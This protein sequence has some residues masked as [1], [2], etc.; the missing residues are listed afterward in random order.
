MAVMKKIT[1]AEQL[2][3]IKRNTVEIIPEGDLYRKLKD[4]YETGIPLKC[5]LGFDP[6]AP[7]LHLGHAVVLHKIREFQDLGHEAVIILGD[8]TGRIGDPTG[9]AEARKQMSEEEVLANARTYREQVYKILDP[10]KTEL[11]FNS[12]W[13]AELKFARIIELSS[14]ITVARMLEREDFSRRYREGVPISLHEFFYPLMQG[15]DSVAIRA[16]VELGATE[17]KFNLLMGRFL[18]K[19][20]GQEPQITLT[21]PILIGTDGLQK[22]SKSLGNYIGITDPPGEMYGKIMSIND[23]SMLEYFSLATRLSPGEIEGIRRD[24]DRGRLHPRDAKMRLGH[25]IVALYHGKEEASRAEEEF[26]RVFQ[27]Q[28]LPDEIPLIHLDSSNW[29]TPADLIRLL[30]HTGMVSSN[31]EARRLIQQGGVRVNGKKIKEMKTNIDISEE[32]L[33]QIG[34]R[35]FIKV[36]IK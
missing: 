34:K 20:Y 12:S 7:D 23:E 36:L 1:P 22:M 25:E 6:S 14:K 17:Q 15:Y 13:L 28:G 9:R 16:D 31:S 2:E 10:A 29:E 8:F 4:S 11:I 33:L 26:R 5:K 24:L 18:Q 30:A 19:E 27:R 3:I 35:K 32:T 21:T